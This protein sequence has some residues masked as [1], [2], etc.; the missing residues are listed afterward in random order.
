MAEAFAISCGAAMKKKIASLQ[1]SM[2][3]PGQ[4][5]KGTLTNS[6][7][8]SDIMKLYLSSIKRA[9]SM[10]QVSANVSARE[11]LLGY[12]PRKEAITAATGILCIQVE[13]HS[14]LHKKK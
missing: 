1:A 6:L 10:N 3:V 9:H 8:L 2:I 4:L 13:E 7:C 5:K 11:I 14:K 12:H